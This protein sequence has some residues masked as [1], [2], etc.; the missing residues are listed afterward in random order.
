MR[1]SLASSYAIVQ[2]HGGDIEVQS[3]LGKGTT[4]KIKLPTKQLT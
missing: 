1:A 4:F 2:R 3:E